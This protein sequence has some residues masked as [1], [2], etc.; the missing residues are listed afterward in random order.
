MARGAGTRSLGLLP[1]LE[2]ST[3]WARE[4]MVSAPGWS[5]PAVTPQSLSLTPCLNPNA[6]SSVA[7][8]F[9]ASS[10]HPFLQLVSLQKLTGIPSWALSWKVTSIS[11]GNMHTGG[12]GCCGVPGY[13]VAEVAALVCSS[14]ARKSPPMKTR[15]KDVTSNTLY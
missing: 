5:A 14:C 2:E 8:V 13:V 6:R 1:A 12:G 3:C 4:Q 9:E 11:D 10:V 7:N 15:L